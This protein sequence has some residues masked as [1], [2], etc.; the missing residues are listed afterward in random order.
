MNKKVL[1]SV[2]SAAILFG[3]CPMTA[4]AEE[5]LHTLNTDIMDFRNAEEDRKG[6][7]W[8]WDA[9]DLTLTLENFYYEVPEGELEEKAAIYLPDEAYVEIEGKD[10]VLDIHSYRCDAFYCEGEVNFYGDGELE[11]TLD[12]SGAD[13]IF[14]KKGPLLIDDEVEITVESKGYV[15]YLDNA[16]GDKTLIS[17]QDD[18]KLIFNKKDHKDRNIVLVKKS[19][20]KTSSNWLD[21]AE[22]DDEWDD[23]YINLVARKAVTKPETEEPAQDEDTSAESAALNEYK[24]I[25][26]AKKILK[27]GEVSYT[28]DVAPYLNKDG[29]TMLPLRALLE[30]SNPEQVVNWNNGTKSAHTFVNNKLVSIKPGEATYTKALDKIVLSTP[31]ETVNGRLFVSLRDWMSIM[32]IDGSQLNWDAATKTVT[33]TY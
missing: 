11:I 10:N 32:E 30:V 21:Y 18:A 7:G 6:D 27:N 19:G 1:C 33:L 22:A 17:I 25:I 5:P 15:I 12:S 16:R 20:V 9:N 29:Y 31:A 3:T 2:L 24:I 26:G 14:V 8:Y 4:F 23:D 28:A 13:A